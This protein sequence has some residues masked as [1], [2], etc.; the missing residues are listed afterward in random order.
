MLNGLI[1]EKYHEE[2]RL[3]TL[4]QERVITN[5]EEVSES[6]KIK[7]KVESLVQKETELQSSEALIVIVTARQSAIDQVKRTDNGTYRALYSENH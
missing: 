3:E 4:Q 6:I 1:S 2:T 7:R 5:S